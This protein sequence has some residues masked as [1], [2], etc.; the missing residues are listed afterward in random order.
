MA[1]WSLPPD[2]TDLVP[3]LRGSNVL[4]T[5]INQSQPFL[6]EEHCPVGR[7]GQKT[8]QFSMKETSIK[9]N[10]ICDTLRSPDQF[11]SCC[12]VQSHL[13]EMDAKKAAGYFTTDHVPNAAEL[14]A[15]K[16]RGLES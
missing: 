7:K 12:A 5:S 2:L 14:A 9:K 4:G 1:V 6:A 11:P 13:L 3:G 10:L 15:P 16:G 8:G